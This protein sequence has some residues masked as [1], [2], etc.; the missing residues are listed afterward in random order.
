MS[1]L[2]AA[3]NPVRLNPKRT[4]AQFKL[5]PEDF[6]VTERLD[7]ADDGEGEHQWLW[8]RKRGANTQF[9][10]R[11][12]ARFADTSPKNVSYA[13][14]KD[15]NA[16]TEQWFSVQL[17]GQETLDW[18]QL[19]NE[20]FQV[21]KVIRRQKKLKLGLHEANQFKIRLRDVVDKGLFE[22]NWNSLVTD[23][24]L[25]YFGPQRF[26]HDQ[27]NLTR[28]FEWLRAG[29]SN[30]RVKKPEQ[31]RLLSSV[32]SFLFNQIAS[33]RYQQYGFETLAG[34]CVMLSGS[35]SVFHVE[36]WDDEL[37]QRLTTGDIQLTAGQPGWVS[38]PL[39]S[40]EAEQFETDCVSPW[41]DIIDCLASKKVKASRRA[42]R[43]KPTD[44]ELC[45][46]GSDAVIYFELPKGSFATACISELIDLSVTENDEDSVE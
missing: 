9:V 19:N 18:Q 27:N 38:K 36:Q 3:I 8:I 22:Q 33:S 20:E 12:L 16:V 44:P 23:G 2:D 32:R 15:R 46:D 45:W 1:Q 35:Q 4:Q 42:M 39:I 40:G 24:T 13:G 31:S 10:A 28:G 37:K 26:G 11:Q 29:G 43:L 34:D 21:L 7:V 17:P 30:K 41:A 6:V 5:H 14:L 25:N